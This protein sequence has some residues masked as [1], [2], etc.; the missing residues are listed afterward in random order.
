MVKSVI[1]SSILCINNSRSRDAHDLQI[2]PVKYVIDSIAPCITF[3]YNLPLSYR[4]FQKNMQVA[5]VIDLFK[6]GNKYELEN[7]RPTSLLPIF[8]RGLDKKIT[9]GL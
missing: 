7:S 6:A 9:H 5:K 4:T 8:S 3:I 1:C 2:R